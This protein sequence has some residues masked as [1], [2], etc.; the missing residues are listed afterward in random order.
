LLQ[1]SSERIE[2]VFNSS[3]TVLV[4]NGYFVDKNMNQERVSPDEIFDSMHESGLDRLE[5]VKW[6]ILESDGKV[7]IVP[8]ERDGNVTPQQQEKE[9]AV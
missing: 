4:Q 6:A 9:L 5:Q 7:A 8:K 2:K 3:P 1:H